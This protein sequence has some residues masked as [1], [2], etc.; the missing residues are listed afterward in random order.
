MRPL[1]GLAAL[2]LLAHAAQAEE[3]LLRDR[4]VVVRAGPFEVFSNAGERSAQQIL[5]DAEQF[6]NA[7][8]VVIG[9]EDLQTIWPIR[10][11]LFES[12][13]DLRRFEIP[14]VLAQG[15]T[16]RFTVLA[17]KS[18]LSTAWF[19]ECARLL[20]E[21]NAGRIPGP[22]QDGLI[23]LFSTVSIDG[24][25][26]TLGA[27]PPKSAQNLEWARAHLLTVSPEYLSKLKILLRNLQTMPAEE[28]AY[29]NAFG[30]TK[31]EIEK[32]AA[33]YLAA[34][35]FDTTMISGLPVNAFRDY[36]PRAVEPDTVES[37]LA[38]LL[39]A[40]PAH[41]VEARAAFGGVLKRGPK[42][43]AEE[44]L[45]LLALA[46]GDKDLAL[47]H[48][49][50]AVEQP[51]AGPRAYLER[52]RLETDH[53]VAI[54]SLKKAAELNPRWPEPHAEMARLAGT[55]GERAAAWAACATRA[56]HNA[57]YWRAYAQAALEAKDYAVATKAWGEAE[58]ASDTEQER[59][60]AQEARLQVDQLRIEGEEA[61]RRRKKQ[62]EFDELERLRQ[63]SLA[64]IREAEAK[65]NAGAQPADPN[66]KVEQWWDDKP[67][68]AK[69]SGMLQ[70]IDCKGGRFILAIASPDRKVARLLMKDPSQT[71]LTGGELAFACGPLP[72]P[73]RVTIDYH[74]QRD[75]S[76]ATIGEVTVIHLE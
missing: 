59:L 34:G 14:G 8:G 25:R 26:V 30:K 74:P 64:R 18:P 33:A 15:R 72:K 48:L 50:R 49:A 4:W 58:K 47:E 22:L 1:A 6:R 20:L 52:A 44:G 24:P 35:R 36:R 71:L 5:G 69:L 39:L 67:A 23:T 31:P 51:G 3:R 9:N 40:N 73:R 53:A 2:A 75:A 37:L 54:A 56:P 63:K 65:A 43:E 17:A 13:R 28:P 10:V 46:Q 57:Q 38:D 68:E 27:L 29:R 66:R 70:R 12:E 42:A 45:G 16:S 11:V 32:E 76:A 19:T 21:V 7:L 61:E 55:P 60:E 41:S 62:A